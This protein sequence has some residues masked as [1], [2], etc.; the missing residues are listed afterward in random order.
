MKYMKLFENK[1][2]KEIIESLEMC[3]QE[4]TDKGFNVDIF[5]KISNWRINFSKKTIISVTNARKLNKIQEKFYEV[6]IYK[7]YNKS[8]IKNIIDNIL[9]T[10]SYIKDEFNLNINQLYIMFHNPM[11]GEL[12]HYYKNIEDL[13]LDDDI[14]S[15]CIYFAKN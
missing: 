1:E 7:K 6:C 5:Q 2:D 9:F 4:L 13:P 12:G 10:E 14:N 8:N 11:F 15:I 3:F